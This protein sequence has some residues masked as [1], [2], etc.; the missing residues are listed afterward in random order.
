MFKKI[1]LLIIL[2]ISWLNIS[3]AYYY[4][5]QFLDGNLTLK[6]NKN[7]RID[8]TLDSYLYNLKSAD[9]VWYLD[10][11]E[12]GK[13]VGMSHVT[14][15]KTSK[16]VSTVGIGIRLNDGR[17]EIINTTILN[18]GISV[19]WENITG[20]KPSW[21]KGRTLT[22]L[23]SKVRVW[24]IVNMLGNDGNN[25]N[26]ANVYYEW[27][28]NGEELPGRSGVG[29]V[30]TDIELPFVV[31][32]NKLR[33]EVRVTNI[34]TNQYLTKKWEIPVFSP[35]L[36][37]YAYKDNTYKY[38]YNN[39]YINW[40]DW[41][42]YI[43][44]FF[45][46]RPYNPLVYGLEI[47]GKYEKLTFPYKDIKLSGPGVN[48]FKINVDVNNPVKILQNDTKSININVNDN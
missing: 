29:M 33:G 21:Y 11:K 19:V 27:R 37:L 2:I 41:R 34:Y 23:G 35:E 36:N 10:D 7:D 9:I 43:E 14:I 46:N 17:S 20:Y 45:F 40:T 1:L 22:S 16:A 30:Y 13:G 4:E 28:L 44:P 26:P 32:D 6:V 39:I 25:T 31:I 3:F 38:L 24:S 47:A 5:E 18:D 15:D 42:L 48:S 12:I 8:L